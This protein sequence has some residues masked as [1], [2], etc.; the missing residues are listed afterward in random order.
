MLSRNHGSRLSVL[1]R[2]PGH[3]NSQLSPSYSP[4]PRFILLAHALSTTFPLRL[5]LGDFHY[6]LLFCLQPKARPSSKPSSGACSAP[7]ALGLNLLAR[8]SLAY[9]P[10]HRE[11]FLPRVH[12]LPNVHLPPHRDDDERE[13]HCILSSHLVKSFALQ[14]SLLALHAVS[15]LVKV[16]QD[17]SSRPRVA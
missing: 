3:M 1:C 13:T 16:F 12:F 8:I 17:F 11:L 6:G 5:L 9:A 2:Y 4:T 10:R 7:T 15:H 14:K